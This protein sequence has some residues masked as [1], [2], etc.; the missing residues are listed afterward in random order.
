MVETAMDKF[1]LKQIFENIGLIHEEDIA[2]LKAILQKYPYYYLP[3][4]VL[5]K[6]YYIQ[7]NEKFDYYLKHAAIRV[8]DRKM[9]YNYI[10]DQKDVNVAELMEDIKEVKN[11]ELVIDVKDETIEQISSENLN[12]ITIVNENELIE[13]TIVEE[14]IH[15]EE[16]LPITN[17]NEFLKDAEL[18]EKDNILEEEPILEQE[19]KNTELEFTI[20]SNDFEDLITIEDSL[21]ETQNEEVEVYATDFTLSQTDN[22]KSELD[23]LLDLRKN[24]LYSIEKS[25]GDKKHLETPISSSEMDFFEWLKHPD[26]INIPKIQIETTKIEEITV[27]NNVGIDLID[28]FINISPQ[29]SRPKKEFFSAENMAKKSEVLELDF[30]SETLANLYLENGNTDLAIQV[31]EKLSL[32]NPSKKA[33]F[34]SLIK[35]IKKENK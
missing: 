27:Q 7:Q 14:D 33:Y 24:P 4:V 20:S 10:H 5:A 8:Q 29:I 30:V 15:Q 13:Q 31:F 11:S 17:V 25:L 16:E 35:K 19:V 22:I 2:E 12:N 23:D 1:R 34:A 26:A 9:L 28:R 6:Y 18:D 21:T 3:Y 32:Q